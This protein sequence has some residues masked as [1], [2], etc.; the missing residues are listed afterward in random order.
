MPDW[1]VIHRRLA[2]AEVL[3][4]YQRQGI[5]T[6]VWTVNADADLA[7]WVASPESMPS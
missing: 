5:R 2:R 1:A 4:R 3:T 6:M 7:P